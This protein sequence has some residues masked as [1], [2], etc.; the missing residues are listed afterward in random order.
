[1][2]DSFDPA[3]STYHRLVN[4]MLVEAGISDRVVFINPSHKEI[5]AYINAADLVVVPSVSTPAWKEQYG[6]V[7][8]EAMACGRIVIASDSGA[9]PDLLKGY[10]YLFHEGDTGSLKKILEDLLNDPGN[11]TFRE[12]DISAYATQ[13]LSIPP[14]SFDGGSIPLKI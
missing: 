7:A 12:S 11:G 6:R 8:A 14:E 10:G 13:Q 2:M 4:K 5:A 9:L 1:M 3:S